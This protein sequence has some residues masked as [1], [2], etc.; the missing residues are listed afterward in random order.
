MGVSHFEQVRAGVGVGLDQLADVGVARG[1]GAVERRTQGLVVGQVG[2]ARI[3]GARRLDVGLGGVGV[4]DF[5][6]HFLLRDRVRA[7]QVLPARGAGLRQFFVS[8][9]LQQVR[10]GLGQLLVQVRAVDFGQHLAGFHRRADVGFPVLQV[11]ADPGV[12]RRLAPGLQVRRQHQGVAGGVVDRLEH[13]DDRHR[14]GFGPARHVVI[15]TGPG[16]Q[17]AGH[18]H[19]GQGQAADAEHHQALAR[20]L[21]CDG[22]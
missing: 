4:G 22:R 19:G 3:V 21:L 9:L 13:A 1:H 20:R 10:M 12:D 17:A 2:E 18:Q 7:Q 14:L 11:A 6:V 5:L 8:L 15:V 16:G